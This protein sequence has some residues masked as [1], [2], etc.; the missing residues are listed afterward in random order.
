GD[1]ENDMDMLRFAGIGVAMGNAAPQVKEAADYI[2]AHIDEDGLEKALRHY[3]L[4]K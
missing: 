3:G 1:G 2:T 4:L